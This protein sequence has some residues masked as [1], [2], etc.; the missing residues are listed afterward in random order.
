MRDGDGALA[1]AA[2]VEAG[3][4]QRER[5]LPA[6][7]LCPSS[8][9]PSSPPDFSFS[10][11]STTTTTPVL[12]FH[13]V[14]ACCARVCLSFL[15]GSRPSQAALPL[16]FRRQ[17]PATSTLPQPSSRCRDSLVFTT[18]SPRL[19]QSLIITYR[20][21]SICRQTL[22]LLSR[23]SAVR[24]SLLSGS[25]IPSQPLPTRRSLKTMSFV[26]RRALLFL[27]SA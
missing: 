15:R 11:S 18:H 10:S 1:A 13:A 9:A 24:P 5:P 14:A 7:P 21:G 20:L 23:H 2:A 19:G 3:A 4:R 12:S 27:C 25:L 22:L 6:Q 17:A 26:Y 16:L 8:L